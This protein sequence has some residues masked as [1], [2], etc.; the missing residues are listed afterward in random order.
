MEEKMKTRIISGAILAGLAILTGYLG[1]PVLLFTLLFCSI[2]GMRELY[3]ATGVIEKG[4]RISV[5]AK[6]AFTAA[7]LYYLAMWLLPVRYVLPVAALCMLIILTTYVLTFPKFTSNQ[8]ITAVFGFFYLAVMLGFMYLTRMKTNNGILTVWLIYISAWGADTAAY[9][10][11]RFFG[12]HKMAPVLS[13]KKTVEGALGGIIGAGLFGVL[14]NLVFDRQQGNVWQF[15][16][17]CACGAVI[18]IFGDLTASAIKRDRGI[19]DYGNLIP[20]H[21]GILDRFD[22]VIFTAPVIYFLSLLLIR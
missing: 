13:P 18:S 14:F 2:V 19:K 16:V 20:G 6:T 3:L 7:V 17:I 9:F 8:A 10:V 4:K 5:I 11:G 12:K 1:G 21:G 15:F 22:S